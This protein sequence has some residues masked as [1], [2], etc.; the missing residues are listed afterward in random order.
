MIAF[1][2]LQPAACS[3]PSIKEEQIRM[4]R[5]IFLPLLLIGAILFALTIG[6]YPL[7]IRDISAFFQAM[8]G[9]KPMAPE[10]YQLLHEFSAFSAARA[11]GR[12]WESCYSATGR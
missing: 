9:L 7:E 10:R 2:P 8:A 4:A 5:L 11:S 3:S 1:R 12:R 6:R